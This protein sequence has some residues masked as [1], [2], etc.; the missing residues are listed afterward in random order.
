MYDPY[1]EFTKHTLPNG[2]EVHHNYWE[3][4]W[5]RVEIIIHSGSREDPLHLPGLA[6]LLEHV[7]NQN[8]PGEDVKEVERFFQV[9]GGE[10]GLGTTSY[11]S[12]RYSFVIPA[13]PMLLR[14]ALQTFGAMMLLEK[15]EKG[16]ELEQKIVLRE[17]TN[18]YPFAEKL[19]WDIAPNEEIFRGHRLETWNRPI[20][21]PEG[22]MVA[23][24]NDLQNFYDKHFVP[25][26]ITLVA[27]GGVMIDDLIA[28]LQST[29][30]G[31]KKEGLRNAVPAPMKS[32]PFPRVTR[33]DV[34]FSDYINV[35]VNQTEYSLSWA[36]PADFPFQA[37]RL[38][39][40]M[41]AHIVNDEIREK[42]QLAYSS[43]VCHYWFQDVVKFEIGGSINPQATN[44]IQDLI[45]RCVAQVEASHELFEWK[46]RQLIAR[47]SLIDLSG[48]DLI[49][50]MSDDLANIQKT[51][52]LAEAHKEV[53]SVTF[54]QMVQAASLLSQRRQFC[55]IKS[56]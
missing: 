14:K 51:E 34:R 29:A 22:F 56:P 23:T 31:L 40:T 53:Q 20:G 25:Q 38:F 7:I 12:T 9:H 45:L 48:E 37:R 46:H 13:D 19:K 1:A 21:R 17:F 36:F 41:L 44:E 32:F 50:E 15:I 2:L 8:I 26:N 54:D 24:K 39:R 18:L 43:H 6:H 35:D 49:D 28:I 27:L 47:H 10:V 52:T 30:F 11:F 55:L 33:K 4:T 42:R 3:R 16:I 5:L